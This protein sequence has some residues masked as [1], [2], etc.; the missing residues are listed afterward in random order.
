MRVLLIKLKN[1]GDTLLLTPVICGIKKRY[2]QS[3]VS[4]VV[5]SGTEAMLAGCSELDE[6]HIVSALEEARSQGVLSELTSICKIRAKQYDWVF[7]LT[8]SN[9]GRW[10]AWLSGAQKRITTSHG[11]PIP[12]YF[13]KCFTAYSAQNW[14]LMHRVEKDYRLVAE[15]IDLETEIPPLTFHVPAGLDPLVGDGRAYA[16]IHPVSRWKRKGWPVERWIETGRALISCGLF[17]IVSAGPDPGEIEIVKRITDELGPSS[18]SIQGS[19][20]WS[21]LARLIK[22][23]SLFVGLDT[24]AMHLA[25]ACQCPVVALFGPSIEH[26]WHPWKSPYEIVSSGGLLHRNYPAFLYDAEKRSMLDIQTEEVISA[27]RR[28]LACS[29]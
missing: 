28:M 18:I 24:A 12:W 6:V 16:I 25:A 20:S 14:H 19:R 1:F 22:H 7:E 29:A 17:L 5:R 23:S 26:H 27:G 13:R 21:E 4:V 10:L 3:H 2:P 8:D 9:H 11:R 15:F